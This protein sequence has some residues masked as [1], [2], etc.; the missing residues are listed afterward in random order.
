MQA[1]QL[2]TP[3]AARADA[4]FIADSGD[5]V[6]ALAQLLTSGGVSLKRLQA[7]GTGLWDDPRVFAEP[8]LEGGWFPAPDRRLSRLHR[9]LSLA[10]R[11]G[12]GAH[13]DPRL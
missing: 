9:S 8:A 13:G 3:A 7:T 1:V 4:V 12:S 10:L 2:I 11:S 6:P 5:A